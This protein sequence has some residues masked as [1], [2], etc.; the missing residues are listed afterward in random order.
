MRS[1]PAWATLG[2]GIAAYDVWACRSGN[3]TLSSGYARALQ[4]HPL[5][6]LAVTAYLVGH[7][8]GPL[9]PAAFARVDVLSIAARRLRP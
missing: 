9:L 2:S 7:L 5:I 6:V 1:G 3:E 8:A 4:H